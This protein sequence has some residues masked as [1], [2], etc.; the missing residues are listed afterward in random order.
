MNALFS[1]ELLPAYMLAIVMSGIIF[2]AGVAMMIVSIVKPWVSK[3]TQGVMCLV[4]GMM[5][6]PVAAM[7]AWGSQPVNLTRQYDLEAL[8]TGTGIR[9][10][11]LYFSSY[12]TY[13]C[14]LDYGDNDHRL[15]SFPASICTLHYDDEGAPHIEVEGEIA[16]H[17][18]DDPNAT[19]MRAERIDIWIPTDSA[20]DEPASSPYSTI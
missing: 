11:F 14:L 4:C 10:T 9:G 1:P 18:E 12:D 16:K 3:L 19:S 6:L 7:L 8:D 20:L 13:K 2:I 17:F 15:E 5:V